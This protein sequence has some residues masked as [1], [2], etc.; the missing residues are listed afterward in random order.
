MITI[1]ASIRAPRIGQRPPILVSSAVRVAVRPAIAPSSV[2]RR[3]V[4]EQCLV[5]EHCTTVVRC[6]QSNREVTVA[7]EGERTERS[8]AAR[9][10]RREERGS[11]RSR[12]SER[13]EHGAR[14]PR[15]SLTLEA[16]LAQATRILDAEGVEGLTLRRLARELGAGTASVYWYID[17][18]DELLQLAY[19][20]TAG[21][22]VRAVLERQID[23]AHWRE[24]LKAAGLA[25][26]EVI[27]AHPWVAEILNSERRG[28]IVILL[29]D[30]LGQLLTSLG[31]T[32][33][34]AFYSA[35][36]LMG[37]FGVAGISAVHEAR[38]EEDRDTRLSRA[39]GAFAAL[40]PQEYPFV[41]RT[42]S[43]YRRHTER[44][45]FLG[46]LELVLDGIASRL[47]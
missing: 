1:A 13:R 21:P 28:E 18:K 9:A 14:T 46:G 10:R 27:E 38:S 23:P 39:V 43:T 20:A 4:L 24:G 15:T 25:L 41:S 17:D 33:E 12:P 2:E 42:I 34:T 3:S 45:Q 7:G 22:P 8:H 47:P 44:E 16:I 19:E 35:S 11:A 26:F 37:L 5:T 32:D 31:F 29:W 40:D 30:R 36:A 6:S